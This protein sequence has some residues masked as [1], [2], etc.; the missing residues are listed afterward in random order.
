M[1]DGKKRHL[2]FYVYR[3]ILTQCWRGS[4]T[5]ADVLLQQLLV[6]IHRDILDEWPMY[7]VM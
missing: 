7:V 5:F 3:I 4:D 6:Y 1:F 2:Y